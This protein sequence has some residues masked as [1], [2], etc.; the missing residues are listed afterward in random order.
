MNKRSFLLLLLIVVTLGLRLYLAFTIPNFTYDSYFSLRQIEQISQKGFPLY[1]DPLSYGGRRIVFLPFF[2]YFFSFFNLFFPLEVFAKILSN[3]LLVSL[4]PLVY[5]I[6]KEIT[7][8]EEPSLFSALISAFIPLLWQTNEVSPLQLFLPLTLLSVY[9]LINL[10]KKKFLYLYFVSFFFLSLTTPATFLFILGFLLYLLFSKIEEKK[11]PRS[12]LELAL[13]SL[14]FFL[15][16]QFLFF[17][18]VLLTAGPKFIWQNIPSPIISQY[19]PKVSI[20]QSLL[21]IGLIPLL[22]GI[23]TTYTSFFREKNKKVFFLF[24]LVVSTLLLFFFNVVEF[25][26]AASF[27]ALILAILFSQFYQN[28]LQYFQKTKIASFKIGRSSFP[29]FVFFCLFLLTLVYPSFSFALGQETPSPE[30]RD[31]F[32]WLKK[33][34]PSS[35]TVLAT[36]KEGHLLTYLSQRK[37]L[38]DSKFFL[39]KGIEERFRHLNSLFT[40]PYQTEAI[41]LLNQ[42]Q[43]SYLFFSPQARKEYSLEELPYLNDKCFSLLYSNVVQI[44]KSKCKLEPVGS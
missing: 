9:S 17:K 16:L 15:W 42:Y 23:F 24:S 36:L 6:A 26:I 21:L 7:Q 13:F 25:K 11:I 35:S 27:L 10:P 5:L 3:L 37:N 20:L 28:F 43:I 12:E 4:I 34:T 22:T 8:K 30:E 32:L 44:Y 40:T 19:F 41:E 14:F 33:N 38:M 1:D 18:E 2:F 31:A 39:V 29:S